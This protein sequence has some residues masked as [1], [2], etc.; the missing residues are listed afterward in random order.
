MPVANLA[1]NFQQATLS[2]DVST[3][4]PDVPVTTGVLPT[5]ASGLVKP[6]APAVQSVTPPKG[7]STMLPPKDFAGPGGVTV[8]SNGG[9]LG[10]TAVDPQ[11]LANGKTSI[12]VAGY[13]TFAGTYSG[14][15][16][17][18]DSG[19]VF[20]EVSA[21]GALSATARSFT[22]TTV[23]ASGSISASGNY[24]ATIGGTTSS[25]G[26]FYG[27]VKSSPAGWNIAGTW[28]GATGLSG[29]FLLTRGCP[30]KT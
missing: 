1:P 14:N 28:N 7:D 9:L 23:A 12:L 6:N 15:Y 24:N 5:E 21:T 11:S 20:A 25:G 4:T 29:T 8:V 18:Q 22:G 19:T 26:G 2:T 13:C 27:A 30:A 3:G 10:R 16:S 17:G